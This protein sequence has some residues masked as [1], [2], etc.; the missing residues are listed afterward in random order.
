MAGVTTRAASMRAEGSA[1]NENAT[2]GPDENITISRAQF[3]EM[4]AEMTAFREQ[5][6]NLPKAAAAP[7]LGDG[8]VPN[9]VPGS[10]PGSTLGSVPVDGSVPGHIPGS[11]SVPVAPVATG[12]YHGKPP[13]V[14]RYS[15]G[16]RGLYNTFMRQCQKAF[17]IENNHT[18]RGRVVFASARLDGTPADD[19]DA[20]E[21]H[22]L[23]P[24]TITWT[25][26]KDVVLAELGD[27]S[28]LMQ[29][30]TDEWHY[31]RQRLE[32][33]VKAYSARLDKLA[34]DMGRRL[35][36]G[37]RTE[38]LRVGLRR[39]VKAKLDEQVFQAKTHRELVAQAQRI[40]HNEEIIRTRSRQPQHDQG[41]RAETH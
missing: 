39:S 33:S 26:F 27:A 11:A 19:W 13:K 21:R 34:E 16:S 36:D 28:N 1:S 5:L 12:I 17:D 41:K 23:T 40:E 7:G 32:K 6:S 18:D 4:Q 3:D 29:Q 9:S 30:L 37:E 8:S 10:V 2:P 15:G 35:T 20:Y 24:G 25:E 38:K 22:H 31:A 14:D